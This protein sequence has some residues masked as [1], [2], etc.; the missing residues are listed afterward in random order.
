[1]TVRVVMLCTSTT[2]DSADR[3][4]L[5]TAPTRNSA[6]MVAV[7]SE[8]NSCFRVEDAEAGK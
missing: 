1:M 4:R 3:D 8:V 5:S 2:G 6:L 7:K